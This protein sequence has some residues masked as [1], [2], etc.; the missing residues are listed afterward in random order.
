MRG[1]LDEQDVVG[2]WSGADGA[3][4][5][6]DGNRRFRVSR[7]P[8]R[9]LFDLNGPGPGERVDAEGAW[10]LREGPSGMEVRLEFDRTGE[11]P[12][13][14]ALNAAIS[15]G[16]WSASLYF[17]DDELHQGRYSLRRTP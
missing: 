11:L 14:F 8:R 16:R 5:E 1:N 6:L 2:V 15:S 12:K 17:A 4:L 13:G 7:F 3:R 10:R 9:L